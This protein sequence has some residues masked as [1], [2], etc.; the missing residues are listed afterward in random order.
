MEITVKYHGKN[1]FGF[2]EYMECT[3]R[4]TE[5]TAK[6]AVAG[7][8]KDRELAIHISDGTENTAFYYDS[9]ADFENG[10]ITV[11]HAKSY[12]NI[13]APVKMSFTKARKMIIDLLKKAA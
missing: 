9:I 3:E 8:K 13:D 11:H 12:Y 1:F 2:N 4:F 7:L 10:I 5:L 6:K